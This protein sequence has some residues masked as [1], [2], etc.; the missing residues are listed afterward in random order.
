MV[1]IWCPSASQAAN[2]YLT[3]HAEQTQD[4]Q[5]DKVAVDMLGFCWWALAEIIQLSPDCMREKG[6]EVLFQIIFIWYEDPTHWGWY[7]E[8]RR[9]LMWCHMRWWREPLGSKCVLL[10]DHHVGSGQREA[11]AINTRRPPAGNSHF[12]HQG[13]KH[14]MY[15]WFGLYCCMFFL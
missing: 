5:S 8:Y 3:C 6:I 15:S 2:S 12:A 7:G 10:A 9:W 4:E 13:N 1:W 11:A 14:C